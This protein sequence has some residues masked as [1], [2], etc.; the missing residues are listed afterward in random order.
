M[1][2]RRLFIIGFLLVLVGCAHTAKLGI[3]MAD[4]YAPVEASLTHIN[5]KVAS[6]LI[7]GIPDKF[8]K[9]EY[10]TAI[11]EVCRT[12]P[13]CLS[14]AKTIFDSYGVK[15]RKVDDVFS[16]MLCD[17][18]GHWKVMED[19]SCNNLRVEVQSWKLNNKVQCDFEDD[20][21]GIIHKY[22]NN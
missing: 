4:T 11:N 16:V 20:W 2:A 8:D 13:V 12:N 3:E 21:A 19:F 6:H 17:K 5:Q 14:E 1:N 18:D 22:C 10:M 15:V 9:D 7:R